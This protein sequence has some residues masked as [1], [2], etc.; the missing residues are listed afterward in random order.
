MNSSSPQPNIPVAARVVDGHVARTSEPAAAVIVVPAIDVSRAADESN[1]GECR[2]CRRAFV[3][4][5]GINDGQ[6]QYYRCKEC[7]EYRL[8]DIIVGSCSIM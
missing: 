6:A 3:R 5:P 4:S 1:I 7:E 2:R 8:Q